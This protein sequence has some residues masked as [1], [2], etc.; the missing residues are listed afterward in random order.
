MFKQIIYLLLLIKLTYC[1][2]HQKQMRIYNYIPQHPSC[3][4]NQRYHENKP[5][6]YLNLQNVSCGKPRK[7]LFKSNDERIRRNPT[8]HNLE[9]YQQQLRGVLTN[10]CFLANCRSNL[11]ENPCHRYYHY[12]IVP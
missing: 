2:C 10:E 6:I 3:L 12:N 7:E 5:R 4:K 1:F 9:M 8:F 11:Q